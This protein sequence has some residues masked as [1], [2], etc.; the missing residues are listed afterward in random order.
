[1]AIGTFNVDDLRVQTALK[2][3]L[4]LGEMRRA[5][6]LIDQFIASHGS[7]NQ[8]LR[9]E[10]SSSGEDSLYQSLDSWLRN[11]HSRIANMMKSQLQELNT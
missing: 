6:R 2:I 10:L 8:R 3:Q 1:M 5:A 11:E 4:L 7:G 9:D